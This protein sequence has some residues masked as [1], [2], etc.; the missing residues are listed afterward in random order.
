MLTGYEKVA[1]DERELVKVS[2][3]YFSNI[4]SNL[5]IQRSVNIALHHD[6]V[7]NAI[8]KLKTTKYTR[9]KKKQVPSDVAFSFSFR[10][11]TLNEIINEIKNLDKSK[12]TQSNDIPTKVIRENY[13]SFA[14]LITEKF[15]NMIENSFFPVSLKQADMKPIYKKYSR[16]EEEN[17]R[18][19]NIL[20]NLSK[21]YE[22]CLYTQLNKYFDPIL[23]KYQ[24][25]FRKGYSA[26][27]C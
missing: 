21:F 6:P 11:T 20:P 12:A 14:I 5:D 24:F 9:D 27:Q 26:Q 18:P 7:L 23:S 4:V 13:D 17:R 2:N 25:G 16:N 15:N 1:S 19:V 22:R 10:K 3:E 8:K